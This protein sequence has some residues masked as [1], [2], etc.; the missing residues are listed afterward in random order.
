MQ[1]FSARQKKSRSRLWHWGLFLAFS[2][3]WIALS[4][5]TL[6]KDIYVL[7][8]YLIGVSSVLLGLLALMAER[9]YLENE[10]VFD[11][12]CFSQGEQYIRLSDVTRLVWLN[13]V[14]PQTDNGGCDVKSGQSK[15]RVLFQYIDDHETL[16]LIKLLRETIPVDRQV[17]W[18]GY[19]HNTGLRI[20]YQVF[21]PNR[22]LPEPTEEEAE[23]Q[24]RFAK[25]RRKMMYGI[26]LVGLVFA[27]L[28]YT[29]LKWIGSPFPFGWAFGVFV[30]ARIAAQAIAFSMFPTPERAFVESQ[31]IWE[32][33]VMA[34]IQ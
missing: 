27:F 11:G 8:Y 28:C 6:P 29:V 2:V 20:Y 13:G 26:L 5:V 30:I 4:F 22:D 9:E 10:V 24:K 33:E 23:S 18:P 16:R 3:G 19:C 32:H 1:K 14:F 15:I 17:N 34:A 7:Y 31:Q 25:C 12:N 21:Y